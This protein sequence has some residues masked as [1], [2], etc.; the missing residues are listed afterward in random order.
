MYTVSQVFGA[1]L[2]I[3]NHISHDIRL[4]RIFMRIYICIG[5]FDEYVAAA[6]SLAR[7]VQTR[8]FHLTNLLA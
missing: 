6:G 7:F 5:E 1:G 3:R 4:A 2:V 8:S